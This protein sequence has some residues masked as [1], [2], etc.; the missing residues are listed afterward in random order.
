VHSGPG[1]EAIRTLSIAGSFCG[2]KA[3][4]TGAEFLTPGQLNEKLLRL[5]ILGVPRPLG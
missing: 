2:D 3:Y 5:G 4:V 1:F